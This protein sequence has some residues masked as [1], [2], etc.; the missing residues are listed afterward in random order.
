MCAMKVCD[1]RNSALAF[2]QKYFSIDADDMSPECS[3][4]GEEE[5]TIG[6]QRPRRPSQGEGGSEKG[7][8]GKS[9]WKKFKL[10]NMDLF[11][12]PSKPD[13]R[14]PKKKRK[15]GSQ[16]EGRRISTLR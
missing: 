5:S 12:R 7:T 13:E 15:A 16:D 11:V 2:A 1:N 14:Q 9:M 3:L 4:M 8:W 10:V 6:R